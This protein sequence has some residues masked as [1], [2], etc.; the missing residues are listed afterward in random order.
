MSGHEHGLRGTHGTGGIGRRGDRRRTAARHDREQGSRDW[1]MLSVAIAVWAASLAAHHTFAWIMGATAGE[2]FNRLAVACAASLALVCGLAVTIGMNGRMPACVRRGRTADERG[3]DDIAEVPIGGGL[4]VVTIAV[5]LSAVAALSA[6]LTQWHDPASTLARERSPVVT[7]DVRIVTPATA[8]DKRGMDCQTDGTITVLYDGDIERASSAAVRVYTSDANCAA[9]ADGATVRAQGTLQQAQYGKQPLWLVVDMP[10]AIAI[11]RRASP[12]K[13]VVA[14]MQDAF[15]AVTER[16]SDQG[17]VLVPGLTLGVLGQDH[18][19]AGGVV[20]DHDRTGIGANTNDNDGTG[21]AA[22][23]DGAVDIPKLNATYAAGVEENFRRS[24]IMHLMAVSGGHFMLIADLTR[25]TCA[26][27]LLPRRLVAGIVAVAYLLLAAIMYPSDSVMRAL[28]MGLFGAAALSVGRRGQSVS[29][30]SWTVIGT[31]LIR[32]RMA[33]SYGFALSCAAVLGIVLFAG[34]VGDRLG[35]F[36]PR[37]LAQPLAMTVAAQSLTLPIQVL[38]EPELP[39]ASVPA[40][41]LVSPFV[42]FATLAGLA[43]LAVSWASPQVGFA[44][45]WVSSGGTQVMERVAAW[46]AGSRYA[47]VPWAGGILGAL[48]MLAA[49][50]ALVALLAVAVPRL[51]RRLRDAFGTQNLRDAY[52]GR[53]ARR[54]LG[55][56]DMRNRRH[57]RSPAPTLP[58]ESFRPGIRSRIN[59]WLAETTTLFGRDFGE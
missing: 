37:F 51:V 31:L 7:A 9:L 26:R 33:T 42:D 18:V 57:S 56:H 48:L 5:L 58:G 20:V 27:F 15:F 54:R 16:L 59:R 49:E 35:A 1:R 52:G 28:V 4:T 44:L 45:A 13:R 23:P 11:V 12:G 19:V 14:H 32:P 41:L 53:D 10:E 55:I 25:R 50:A 40:N 17:R 21:A 24:G 22:Q 39:L 29:A 3:P 38:M 36:M 8:A 30:L 6:N 2:R 34:V 47:V 43:A 46:L